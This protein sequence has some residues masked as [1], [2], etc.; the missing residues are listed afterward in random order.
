M[1]SLL[2]FISERLR[3]SGPSI[4]A[5]SRMTVRFCTLSAPNRE[6]EP[7]LKQHGLYLLHI[8]ICT[9]QCEG[10]G[11]LSSQPALLLIWSS[12]EPFILFNSSAQLFFL[13]T[14]F[15]TPSGSLRENG[16]VKSRGSRF[17]LKFHSHHKITQVCFLSWKIYQI[18][19]DLR[20]NSSIFLYT[21]FILLCSFLSLTFDS[22]W[23]ISFLPLE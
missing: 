7:S 11:F 3:A 13:A 21:F 5:S 9:H 22:N 10:G 2:W 20:L 19:E 6:G 15:Y 23:L 4:T 16:H 18:T 14:L 17:N 1:F 12:Q 8:F